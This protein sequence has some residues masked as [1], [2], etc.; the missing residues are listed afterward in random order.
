MFVWLQL[1]I[2]NLQIF[3]K[4]YFKNGAYLVLDVTIYTLNRSPKDL[5]TNLVLG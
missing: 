3:F 1:T 4:P 5:S 2:I